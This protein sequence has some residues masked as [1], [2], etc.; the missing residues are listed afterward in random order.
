MHGLAA[1]YYAQAAENITN[2]GQAD[3]ENNLPEKSN[4]EKKCDKDLVLSFT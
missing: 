4:D 2:C 3:G 1:Q